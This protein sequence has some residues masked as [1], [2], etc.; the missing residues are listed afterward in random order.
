[1]VAEPLWCCKI[2]LWLEAEVCN[3]WVY[4]HSSCWFY[5]LNFYFKFYLLCTHNVSCLSL[6]HSLIIPKSH[7]SSLEATPPSVSTLRSMRAASEVFMNCFAEDF[8]LNWCKWLPY[9]YQVLLCQTKVPQLKLKWRVH[10]KEA[11]Y[12]TFSVKSIGIKILSQ[13]RSTYGWC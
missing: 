7:F 4:S 5:Y 13:L 11:T 8:P 1:M 10:V 2:I 6:R 3:S 12:G 9:V